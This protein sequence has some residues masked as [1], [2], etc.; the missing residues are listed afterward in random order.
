MEFE[1]EADARA[2]IDNM[3]GAYECSRYIPVF[4]LKVQVLCVLCS[5]TRVGAFREDAAR[6]HREA[7]PTETRL[8]QARCVAK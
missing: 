1:D 7:G 3:D 2:A 8:K 4:R 6:L 5:I